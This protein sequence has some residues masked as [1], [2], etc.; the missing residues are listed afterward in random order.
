MNNDIIQDLLDNEARL[1]NER[2]VILQQIKQLRGDTPPTCWGQDDCST[3]MLSR[4]PWR[5][6]CGSPKD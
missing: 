3:M 6:D 1:S 2:Y 4:C 5:I